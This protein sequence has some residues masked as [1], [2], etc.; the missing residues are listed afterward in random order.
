MP[1][2]NPITDAELAELRGLREAAANGLNWQEAA[3]FQALMVERFPAIIERLENA[4][5]YRA[6]VEAAKPTVQALLD[7]GER[8]ASEVADLRQRLEAAERDRDELREY[9]EAETTRRAKADCYDRIC[10][11]LGVESN[12][13]GSIAARDAQQRREGTIKALKSLKGMALWNGDP[14][15]MDHAVDLAAKR[16]REGGE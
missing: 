10:E 9:R 5:A 1:E 2:N 15:D 11:H 8:A 3:Q 16:L 6:E 13:L 12:V 7:S 14:A 4:E